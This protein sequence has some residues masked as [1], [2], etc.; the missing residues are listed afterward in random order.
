LS[1]FIIST[2]IFEKVA[3]QEL[4]I[5]IASDT[6]ESIVRSVASR[7]QGNE[8]LKREFLTYK[9]VYTLDNLNN[10]GQVISR[11][12]EEV[13]SIDFGGKEE[14]LEVNG[15][16]VKK[17]KATSARFDLSNVLDAL[18]KLDDFKVVKIDRIEDRHF[19]I[20]N[21]KPKPKVKHTGDVEDVLVRSEG[22]IAVDIE[23]FYIKKLSARLVKNYDRALGI[24]SL[25]YA[26]MEIEQEDLNGIVVMK[27][28]DLVDKYWI[29][30]KGNT[31]E[32]QTFTYK[33]YQ[34]KN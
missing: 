2:P 34:R 5:P 14:L 9:R 32:K 30:L 17:T 22:V 18:L 3:G 13:V 4:Q 26:N 1:L 6:G 21:F 7:I 25:S 31:F 19:Y 29:F 10:E 15:K 16:P 8:K 24:F 27:H 23:K 12:K 20:I 33:D 11:K 28:I